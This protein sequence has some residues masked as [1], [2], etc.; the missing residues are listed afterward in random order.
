MEAW[1]RSHEARLPV[2][3]QST[4]VWPTNNS[5][6]AELSLP[7]RTRQILRYD[8]GRDASWTDADG[9]RWQAIFLR[10][11]PGSTAAFLANNHTP[12]I[13]VTAAGRKLISSSELKWFDV[14]G[15][16]MPFRA[17]TFADAGGRLHVFYC[18]WNDRANGQSFA[19]ASLDY[20]RRLKSVLSGQRNSGQRSI[21]LAVSGV[22]D[23]AAAENRAR[24][25]L[26]KI[27]AVKK[28]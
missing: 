18:L 28:W 2:T 3:T 20:Q 5:F 16:K 17:Y 8:E 7:E 25:E 15:L 9:A 1:Y 19:T 11:N 14:N 23:S 13:C 21:E 22:E 26:K 27:V 10:W 12:E 4:V 24:V 6:F